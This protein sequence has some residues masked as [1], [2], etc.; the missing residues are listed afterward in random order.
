MSADTL[1]ALDG[2]GPQKVMADDCFWEVEDDEEKTELGGKK[3]TVTLVKM[4]KTRGNRH[5]KSVV[6]G[7]PR[8]DTAAF[9]PPVLPVPAGDPH[10]L[11]EA[12]DS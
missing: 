4:E 5:W 11:R 8:I 6:V 2:Y 12:L 10:A 3:L 1:A 7:A 9:G